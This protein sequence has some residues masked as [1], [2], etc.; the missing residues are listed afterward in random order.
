[1]QPNNQSVTMM[2]HLLVLRED[3]IIAGVEESE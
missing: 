1:M 3:E 2:T